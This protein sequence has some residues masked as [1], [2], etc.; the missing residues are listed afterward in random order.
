MNARRFWI[1]GLLLAMMLSFGWDA[2]GA[3]D[4]FLKLAGVEG[5]SADARHPKEIDVLSWSWGLTNSGSVVTGGGKVQI[6][7][8]SFT[9]YV[10]KSS[11]PLMLATCNGKAFTQAVF[12]FRRAGSSPIEYMRVTLTDVTV[13]SVSTSASTA[14]SRPTEVVNLRFATVKVDYTVQNADGSAGTVVSFGWDVLRNTA[15]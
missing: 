10:D 8:I 13:A 2:R 15:L 9:K 7:D 1:A 3:T 4:I 11:P 14:D 5:E 6:K 12:V